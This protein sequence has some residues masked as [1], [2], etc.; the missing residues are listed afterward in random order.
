MDEKEI[1]QNGKKLIDDIV[2]TSI[3]IS[4]SIAEIDVLLKK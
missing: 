1:N 4:E 3:E 2:K